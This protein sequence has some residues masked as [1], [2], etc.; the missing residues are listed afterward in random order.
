MV[1]LVFELWSALSS[2]LAAV[3]ALGLLIFAHEFGHFIVAK[4]SGVHVLKFSLGFGK[5]LFGW[6]IGDTDYMVSA[7]PLGGYVKM[8]GE[9]EDGEELTPEQKKHSFLAQPVYKR[10]L[11]VFAGPLFNILLAVTLCYMLFITGFPTAIAKVTAVGPDTPAAAAGFRAGDIIESE[12][13]DY[14]N[15]WEEVEEYVK[16][17]PGKEITF[18]VRRD[19]GK[20][21]IKA[22]PADIGG[23]GDLGLYGSAV[24]AAVMVGSPA[25]KAGLQPKDQIVKVDG[26]LVGSWADMA[27]VVKASPGKTL[28]F[29]VQRD[30]RLLDLKITPTLKEDARKGEK[31]YGVIGVQAGVESEN[32]A[33]GPIESVGMSVNKTMYMTGFTVAFLGRIVKGKEDASQIGGPV[34]I[35]QMSGRQARQGFADFVIFMALLSVN[36][37]IINLFPIPILDGGHLFFFG[38]EAVLGK[39]LSMRKREIAQQVGLFLLIALMVFVFYNDIMR[40]LGFSVMWK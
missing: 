17:H 2:V 40:L 24:L 10:A 31:P 26:K 20:L 30:G 16:T 34:A 7:F 6:R 23:K 38:I 8:L 25:D 29:S 39:P 33:Y 13:G 35:V 19:G 14:A 9:E 22:R 21:T 3:V 5:R 36:L 32:V 28:D 27:D 18:V 12:D 4:L 1:H 11:I 15:S 37:G